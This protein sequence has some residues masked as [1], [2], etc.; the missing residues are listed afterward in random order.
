M[1][2]MFQPNLWLPARDCWVSCF[3]P[4]YGCLPAI[5][6]FHVSTQPMVACPRLL[7]F[8]LQPNLR[9]LVRDCWVSMFQP[10]GSLV[11]NTSLFNQQ[12]DEAYHS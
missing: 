12:I 3:N 10:T 6:G 11:L 2:F 7:G 1:G 5:V 8:M 4:T 9:L